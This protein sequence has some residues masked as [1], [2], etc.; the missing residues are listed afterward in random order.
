MT[1]HHNDDT[2]RRDDIAEEFYARPYDR[3]FRLEKKHVDVVIQ[4][5]HQYAQACEA[6]LIHEIFGDIPDTWR[7]SPKGVSMTRGDM[8]ALIDTVRQ[9]NNQRKVAHL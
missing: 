8:Y 4:L 5:F 9:R 7:D 1:Q 3:L 2:E 6:E